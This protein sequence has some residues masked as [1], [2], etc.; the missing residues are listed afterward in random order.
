MAAVVRRAHALFA[1]STG[2][3]LPT[4]ADNVFP[5][6]SRLQD[7]IDRPG[8]SREMLAALHAV[9][10]GRFG[11]DSHYFVSEHR[12]GEEHPCFDSAYYLMVTYVTFCAPALQRRGFLMA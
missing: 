1:E 8:S 9:A 5:R 6:P 10:E 11:A 3:R 12:L 4:I 2:P 7:A